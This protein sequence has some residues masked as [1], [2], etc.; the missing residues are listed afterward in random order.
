MLRITRIGLM[1]GF[2][3]T[4]AAGLALGAFAQP[5]VFTV[6]GQPGAPDVQTVILQDL[7]KRINPSVV[8]LEV[9]IPTTSPNLDLLPN[10]N[11]DNNNQQP[12]PNVRASGSGFI[13]NDQGYIVTNAHVVED[14][15]KITVI[16]EDATTITA[17][18]I[19]A[20]RDSDLAV[21]KVDA[22]KVTLPPALELAD[23]DKVAVGERAV[24]FGSPFEL[25]GTMTE[26]IISAVDRSLLG[27]RVGTSSYRI[28]RVLQTDAAINPGNSG[29]PLV[30]VNGQVLGV[31]TA[32]W[33]RVRQSSGVGFA[34]PSNLIKRVVPELIETGKIAH[35]YLGITGGNVTVAINEAMKIDPK[36]KGVLVREVAAGGPAAK[37][38]VKAG[39]QEVTIDDIPIMLGGD[40]I[41]KVDDVDVRFFD[42]LLAYLFFNTK[43][44]QDVT[45]TVI[46]GSETKTITVT[47]GTRPT[48]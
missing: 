30:N 41:V 14:A 25:P 2:T 45:L 36:T 6:K 12:Q 22:T 35:S 39:D 11:E 9:Q 42:D 18:L 15:V 31:N 28:P 24:A 27:R 7:Y 48:D 33:S 47:L 21:I 26:G 4:L 10:E 8:T 34:V 29:G 43:P 20:D 16:F 38:G 5:A 23:S 37:A 17:D 46:R 1:A 19:G 44:G 32:I 40:I 3:L 13:W